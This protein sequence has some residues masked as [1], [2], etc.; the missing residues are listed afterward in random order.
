MNDQRMEINPKTRKYLEHREFNREE[1]ASSSLKSVNWKRLFKYLMPYKLLMSLS[2]LSMF[3]SSGFTLLFPFVIIKFVDSAANDI[4]IHKLNYLLVIMVAIIIGLSIFRF[5]STL[6]SAYVGEKIIFDLRTSLYGHMIRF[7][8]DFFNKNRVGELLSRL[9]MDVMQVRM[10]L[11]EDLAMII[12]NTLRLIGSV[13]I[14]IYLS[15]TFA[16]AILILAPVFAIIM[17]IFGKA[18]NKRG[19]E[20]HF[21]YAELSTIA[22]ESL[23]CIRVIKSFGSEAFEGQR[24]KNLA[25]KILHTCVRLTVDTTLLVTISQFVGLFAISLV[26]WQGG[27]QVITGNISIGII[28]GFLAYGITIALSVTSLAEFFGKLNVCLGAVTYVFKILDTRPSVN[29]KPEAI[30]ITSCQGRIAIKNVDFSYDNSATVLKDI[31]LDIKAGEILAIVGPSGAGKT[32][33]FNL[34]PRFYDPDKGSVHI[35][36]LDLKDI[37]Q[38]SLRKQLAIVPQETILFGGTIRENILYGRMEATE[39]EMVAAAKDANAHDFII[40]FPDQYDTVVGERGMRLSGGER[41]RIAIAR[42]ILK[43]PHVLLLD[44]ATS[45]LDNESEKLVQEALDRL[46]KNRTTIII[47]HRLSTIKIANRIAVMENGSL[48]ENGNHKELMEENGL[49]SRLYLMQFRYTREEM[50]NNIERIDDRKKIV[51]K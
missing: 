42:A 9:Q 1:I 11:T 29:D 45:S 17:D 50:D 43:D 3:I 22:E 28:T 13:A 44:E 18:L 10:L 48:V 25:K 26:I 41:Q 39:D 2:L 7:S 51:Y 49:Y 32:T 35:D 46:M 31:S 33:L 5:L 16:L 24:Y 20:K 34:I 8:L 37:T 47:A 19:M 23:Q 40:S 30:E 36:G 4:N 21:Q 14:M 12:S 15:W 38:E 27:R 6:L